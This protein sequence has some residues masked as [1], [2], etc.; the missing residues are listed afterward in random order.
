MLLLR[1]L[2][3]EYS[4]IHPDQ[5]SAHV[6]KIR[7]QAW[8]IRAY[9]CTGLGIFL[10]PVLPRSPAY[11]LVLS[12]LKA[13]GYFLDVGCHLGGDMRRLAFDGAPTDH[14]IG[15]DIVSHWDLGFDLFRDTGRF[16]A[17]FVE[18][19]LLSLVPQ[20]GDR[21]DD[22]EDNANTKAF[23]LLHGQMDVISISA[24]LHQWALE[25]QVEAAKRLVP[26]SSGPGAMLLGYQ[27]GNTEAQEIV[28][29]STVVPQF[30]HNPSSFRL[31]WEQVG[32]E[33][34]TLWKTEAKFLEWQDAGWDTEDYA[35]MAEGDRVLDFVVTRIE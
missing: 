9:P 19:D 29:P 32:R 22:D 2:L 16:K 10:L 31:M 27:I 25:Q 17:Q 18:A 20:T 5:Q 34:G 3:H 4:G 26:L 11:P 15:L 24:V 7:D 35:W 6:H 8:A 12:T 13:G 1:R 28:M 23:N 30:R 33:T 14:M 21:K